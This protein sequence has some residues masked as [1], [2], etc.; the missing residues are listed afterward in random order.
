MRLSFSQW[1]KLQRVFKD[2]SQAHIASK[3]GV[4]PQTVSNWETGRSGVSL[5]P[6]QTYKLCVV[7]GCDLG[8]LAKAFRG[9]VVL[10]DFAPD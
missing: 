9:E 4:T 10:T 3:L 8:Q 2:I 6:D 5:T 1:F 7:I